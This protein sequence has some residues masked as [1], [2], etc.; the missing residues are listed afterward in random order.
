MHVSLLGAH[1]VMQVANA[2]AQL[3]EQLF[4]PQRRKRQLAG[5]HGWIIGGNI[6]HSSLKLR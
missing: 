3:I 4:G 1:A 5:F 2:L 6:Q